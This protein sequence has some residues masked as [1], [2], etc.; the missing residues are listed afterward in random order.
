MFAPLGHTS[1]TPNIYSFNSALSPYKKISLFNH[2]AA[3]QR[4]ALLAPQGKTSPP[5]G[6]SLSPLKTFS[7]QTHL[8]RLPR[9]ARPLRYSCTFLPPLLN[10]PSNK[11]ALRVFAPTGLFPRIHRKIKCLFAHPTPI[12]NI[13]QSSNR[14]TPTAPPRPTPA[15]HCTTTPYASFPLHHHALRQLPTAPHQTPSATPAPISGRRPSHTNASI[16]PP[17]PP[18]HPSASIT[19]PEPTSNRHPSPAPFSSKICR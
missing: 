9:R 6:T 15:S 1:T 2:P 13:S 3:K 11:H 10:I 18:P 5:A 8:V 17:P 7:R 14:P 19:S 4:Q 16:P 12:T